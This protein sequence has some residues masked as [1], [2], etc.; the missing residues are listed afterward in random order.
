MLLHRE[1]S[2]DTQDGWTVTRSRRSSCAV[3]AAVAVAATVAVAVVTAVAHSVRVKTNIYY[4]VIN[5]SKLNSVSE[6]KFTVPC[7][8][9]GI[10]FT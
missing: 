5:Q 3:A 6:V 8:G 4:I 10:P 7:C 9:T 2:I 1:A